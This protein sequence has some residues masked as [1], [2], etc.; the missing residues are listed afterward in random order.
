MAD[1]PYRAPK[2]HASASET[3]GRKRPRPATWYVLATVAALAGFCAAW[4]LVALLVMLIIVPFTDTSGWEMPPYAI[5]LSV[6]VG[7]APFVAVCL[8]CLAV[9]RRITR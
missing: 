8:V 2:N 7:S 6:T 9:M 4:G 3:E 5:C 1:N